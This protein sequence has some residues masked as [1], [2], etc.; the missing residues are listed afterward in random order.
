MKLTQEIKH[1]P[2]MNLE[3]QDFDMNTENDSGGLGLKF[4]PI[5]IR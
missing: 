3:K 5:V 1:S 4:R 2:E